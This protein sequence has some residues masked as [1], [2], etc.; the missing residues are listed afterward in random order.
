MPI[1]IVFPVVLIEDI[2]QCSMGRTNYEK[3]VYAQLWKPS[4]QDASLFSL[5]EKL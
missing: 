4:F 1:I 3:L 5:S 2:I